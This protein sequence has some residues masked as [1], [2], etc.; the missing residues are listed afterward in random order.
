MRRARRSSLL[1]LIAFATVA[2]QPA[3]PP[4]E[5]L[6]RQQI[7]QA[8]KARA[9][10]LA[11]QQQASA[12]AAAAAAEAERLA[13]ERVAAAARLRD[14]ETAT[15]DVAARMDQLAARR[16]Q[17]QADL[18][19]RA[20]EMQPLLPLIERL[21]LFPAETLLAVPAQPEDTLRGVLVL[22]GI[23]G[24]LG[25]EAVALRHEQVRLAM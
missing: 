8:D 25:Q 24:Q 13:A 4:K 5:D 15:A 12:R 6:T 2:A 16:R 10:E 17:A 7:E 18:D 21:S 20:E 9:A 11:A 3:R 22:R 19:A 14:A 23:A 1:A